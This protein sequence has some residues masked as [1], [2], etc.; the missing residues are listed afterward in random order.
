MGL[1]FAERRDAASPPKVRDSSA[2]VRRTC[3]CGGATGPDG[4]CDRCRERA[5]RNL[6]R[7]AVAAAP[8]PEVAPHAVHE[9]LRSPGEPL[10][11]G[12]RRWMEPHLGRDLGDVRVHTDARAADSARAVAARAYT[13]GRRIVFG[14]GAYAPATGDGRRLLAHELTHV[15]QQEG[16]P[17]PPG[18]L[19]IGRPGD[20]AER[21][22]ERVSASAA[23]AEA[24]GGGARPAV[25]RAGPIYRPRLQRQ[26]GGAP[27]PAPTAAPSR[28]VYLCSKSLDTSPVGS[29]AFF[30]IGGAGKGN[31]TLSLQPVDSS[32]G[33]D[34]WQGIPG[35]DYP[36][37]LDAEGSCE[38]T[39]ITETCLDTQYS[40][41]PI[42]HYCT[43]GPNSNTFVGHLARKCGM[44]KP[45]PA[46]WTP[47]ID[48]SPPPGGTFAPDKWT[49]MS[50]C[51]TKQ[52]VINP[53]APKGPV[54]G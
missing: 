24:A 27:A 5:L 14:A 6:Q 18:T 3:A 10:D 44:A 28:T 51:T 9:V 42:G 33:A 40:A 19:E 20:G 8:Q 36:S 35:R 4:M 46:G 26:G 21:E 48:G 54:I 30:R 15:A 11:A 38:P 22:A 1:A 39:A 49:T 12:V 31:T 41:Y 17:G 7:A 45:D 25:G 47:G 34:C 23:A 29:H 43:L 53:P 32:L 16:A 2:V 37:D 13:V 52:C 50:G